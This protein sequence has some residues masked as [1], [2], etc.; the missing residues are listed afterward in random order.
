MTSGRALAGDALDSA[1]GLGVT[2]SFVLRLA[3]TGGLAFGFLDV[4]SDF[5]LGGF[6]VPIA[7]WGLVRGA[8]LSLAGLRSVFEAAERGDDAS[9]G[10]KVTLAGPWLAAGA[11]RV[12]GKGRGGNSPAGCGVAGFAGT[13]TARNSG[14]STRLSC[15][16][17]AKPG[18]PN[19]WPPKVRLNNRAWNRMDSSSETSSR[20]PGWLASR[21]G[22]R[23]TMAASSMD[24]K[25][26]SW[27]GLSIPE[28]VVG[29]KREPPAAWGW[30]GSQKAV[31]SFAGRSESSGET[32]RHGRDWASV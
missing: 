7:A 1:F 25:G 12:G 2:F 3:V 14:T 21:N 20:L 11:A 18:G 22:C 4:E 13:S 29:F 17:R 10:R 31:H 9:G 32:A 16:G 19:S 8:A 5:A 30:H 26:W 23:R 15:Q 24:S 6:R 28:A 27:G